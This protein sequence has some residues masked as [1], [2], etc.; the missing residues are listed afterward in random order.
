MS[1]NVNRG[2][3]ATRRQTATTRT[4]SQVNR[5]IVLDTLRTSGPMSRQRIIDETGL[6]PATV[7]RLLDTLKADRLVT[8]DERAPSRGGRPAQ[9]I[10]FNAQAQ[11]V[12]ALTLGSDTLHGAVCDLTGHTRHHLNRPLHE[13]D[14]APALIEQVIAFATQ[15]SQ[16]ADALGA[17][18][19]A[20]AVGVP[21]VATGHDGLVEFAPALGWS[22]M[23][24]GVRLTEELGIPAAIENDV[25][26]IALAAHRHTAPPG[27]QHLVA[28]VADTG[29]GAG[30]VLG[31]QLHRGRLGA[32]GEV[33]YLLMERRSLN[34][35]WPGFGDLES[36]VGLNGI[37]Q[38][39]AEA[40]S[41][42]GIDGSDAP[43]YAALQHLF[44]AARHS[45]PAAGRLVRQLADDFALVIADIAVLISPDVV[46][47]GGRTFHHGGDL[48]IPAI[49]TRLQGRIPHVPPLTPIDADQLQL[50]GA[51]ELALETTAI[52]TPTLR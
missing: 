22:S 14:G 52:T 12:L 32:A 47:L 2:T 30:L 9:L 27:V 13:G 18:P 4:V 23:P 45:E 11:S 17:P 43:G 24:L 31:G 6:S 49:E 29:V 36:S 48:L 46:A 40:D 19:R 35:P 42:G 15:L 21:G 37:R 8:D 33:G 39:I 51:A 26:L 16:A 44:T 3:P 5:T 1:G 34:R 38:R 25:N 28:L 41:N 7:N 50:T 20:V 10:R